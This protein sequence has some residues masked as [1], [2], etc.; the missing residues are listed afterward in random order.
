MNCN[1][2]VV[3]FSGLTVSLRS[4]SGMWVPI[5]IPPHPLFGGESAD[6]RLHNSSSRVIR[7][8]VGIFRTHPFPHWV[9][10]HQDLTNLGK[11]EDRP[12]GGGRLRVP[13]YRELLPGGSATF[14]LEVPDGCG[15]LGVRFG[16]RR[17]GRYWCPVVLARG[18]V[19]L[20][21][22]EDHGWELVGSAMW[23]AGL[24]VWG[25]LCLDV[26]TESGE[27][28][29]TPIWWGAWSGLILALALITG[30]VIRHEFW[31]NW[32]FWRRPGPVGSLTRQIATLGGIVAVFWSFA[33][34]LT[35]LLF[36][37][38]KVNATPQPS[39][40]QVM[41]TSLQWFGNELLGSIPV[42][43]IP[44]TFGLNPPVEY[45]G[46]SAAVILTLFRLLLLVPVVAVLSAAYNRAKASVGTP[47]DD[48]LTML[49]PPDPSRPE[50]PTPPPSPAP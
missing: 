38:G 22:G 44:E 15:V 23:A 26:G 25:E 13:R 14:Q 41:E 37:L 47:V 28:A 27:E 33:T 29:L 24:Y 8:Q 32:I 48:P 5:T 49:D 31:R 43:K 20:D 4:D 50:Q 12:G 6:V 17:A 1:T 34:Y 7:F 40:D 36:S 45:S 2:W 16:G 30:Y 19:A 10:I 3:P 42:L 9:P 11:W 35:A 46:F 39:V 18:G 21:D